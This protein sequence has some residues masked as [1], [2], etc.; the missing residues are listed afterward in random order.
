LNGLCCVFC[1]VCLFKKDP[2]KAGPWWRTPFTPALWRQR[3]EDLL[4]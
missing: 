3:Q 1:L 4:S 2:C